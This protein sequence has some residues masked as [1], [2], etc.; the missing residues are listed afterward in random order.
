M[1]FF[2]SINLITGSILPPEIPLRP[3]RIGKNLKNSTFRNIGNKG[4]YTTKASQK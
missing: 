2:A 1:S 4:I 3:T